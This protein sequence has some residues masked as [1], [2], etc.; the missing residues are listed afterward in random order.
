MYLQVGRQMAKFE[1]AGGIGGWDQ[2]AEMASHAKSP[3]LDR[4]PAAVAAAIGI[5]SGSPPAR[6]R[7]AAAPR[8]CGAS[9]QR[10]RS[11]SPCR[12][13]P[14]AKRAAPSTPSTL[15]AW[16]PLYHS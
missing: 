8:P 16:R 7:A 13:R 15:R 3:L 10:I 1:L 5:S 4:H 11:K 2:D 9:A 6:N 14:L 12:P